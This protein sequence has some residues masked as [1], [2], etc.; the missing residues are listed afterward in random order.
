[1]DRLRPWSPRVETGR[2]SRVLPPSYFLHFQ[3]LLSF[4]DF[5]FPPNPTTNVPVQT[6]LHGGAVCPISWC[7]GLSFHGLSKVVSDGTLTWP[8]SRVSHALGPFLAFLVHPR[9]AAGCTPLPPCSAA[10]F[11][12]DWTVC[13]GALTL[14]LCV[15]CLVLA[16]SPAPAEPCWESLTQDTAQACPPPRASLCCMP[17]PAWVP[18]A[19]ASLLQT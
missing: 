2:H 1:M 8:L 4:A 17:G 3:R 9:P 14:H 5:T 15:C 19:P 13:S 16:S 12:A 10:I 18:R 11:H 7:S 6:E